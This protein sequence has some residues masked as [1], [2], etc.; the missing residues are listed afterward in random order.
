M[1]LCRW[2]FLVGYTFFCNY[3]LFHLTNCVG[4]FGVV[5]GC[6]GLFLNC[7]WLT[8]WQEAAPLVR[9][10]HGWR[11]RYLPV[12]PDQ[13]VVGSGDGRRWCWRIWFVVYAWP[14]RACNAWIRSFV[15]WIN[16]CLQWR[17]KKQG[18]LGKYKR[19]ESLKMN[20]L[21]KCK[22]ETKLPHHRECQLAMAVWSRP[23]VGSNPSPGR[24]NG[25]GR[26]FRRPDLWL[27]D[28]TAA[29]TFFDCWSSLSFRF[30]GLKNVRRGKKIPAKRSVCVTKNTKGRE[31]HKRAKRTLTTH[32]QWHWQVRETKV[33]PLPCPWFLPRQFQ[34]WTL[35]TR[36]RMGLQ[37]VASRTNGW[38]S[39]SPAL[40]LWCGSLVKQRL[41]KSLNSF[42]HLLGSVQGRRVRLLD[43]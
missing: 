40:G 34:L 33:L 25:W 26:S 32:Q 28:S 37:S 24:R 13:L 20:T 9:S 31:R 43:S 10:F 14:S 11:G 1:K 30:W 36:S 3:Y 27:P 39:N 17:Q 35:S 38:W 22:F 16:R 8:V 29:C 23:A 2:R 21:L 6:V 42:D 7:S 19:L 18:H 4:G 5:V 41:T 15:H 12:S